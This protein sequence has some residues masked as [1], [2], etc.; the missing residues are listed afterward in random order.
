[1][2]GTDDDG[3]QSGEEIEPN[4]DPFGSTDPDGQGLGKVA[5]HEFNS[6]LMGR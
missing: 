5:F 6:S 4:P 2:I 1:M 3:D